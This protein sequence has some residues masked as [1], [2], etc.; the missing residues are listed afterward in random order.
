MTASEKWLSTSYGVA[1]AGC[2]TLA[3]GPL[4]SGL[5]RREEQSATTAVATTDSS[6]LGESVWPMQRA[7][8]EHHDHVDADHEA[9]Q[10]RAHD[11]PVP[12]AAMTPERPRAGSACGSV[13]LIGTHA[14]RARPHR[15]G[16]ASRTSAPTAGAQRLEP[17][18]SR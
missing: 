15:G 10:D 17:L 4:E 8:A 13:R 9:R 7:T 18:A 12:H 6:R 11:Q 3:R 14:G 1:A 5:D 2:P 16:G